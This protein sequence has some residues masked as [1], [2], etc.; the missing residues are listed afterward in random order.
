MLVAHFYEHREAVSPSDVVT[1][2]LGV[3]ALWQP[4]RVTSL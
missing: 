4:Y 1:L 3:R 2:P